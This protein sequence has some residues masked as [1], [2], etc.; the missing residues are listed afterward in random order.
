MTD[1]S[2]ES[3]ATTDADLPAP[4]AG[5]GQETPRRAARLMRNPLLRIAAVLV[6]F[7]LGW[8]AFHAAQ[9]LWAGRNDNTPVSASSQALSGALSVSGHGV[10]LTFPHGWVNVPTTPADLAKF[11]QANVGKFPHLTAALKS[12][13][14]NLQNLR[15]MAMFVV[16]VSPGGAITGNTNVVVIAAAAPPPR[17]LIPQIRAGLAQLGATD[18]HASLAT[19]G[20]HPSLLVTYTL[21]S[22]AGLPA[23]YGAQAYIRGS[24][25]TPVITVTTSGTANAGTTLR[26]IAG[27][28]K[29]S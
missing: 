26:Q 13:L 10:T 17:Q 5:G 27:T 25:D 12:Q 18:E 28:I 23:R 9:D 19:F 15:S 14:G 16:R 20:T 6:G 24:T 4:G 22:H 3:A 21:P 2:P 1:I 8:G 11:M 29:F 7:A